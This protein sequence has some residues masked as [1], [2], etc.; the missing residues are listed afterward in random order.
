MQYGSALAIQS[1][2]LLMAYMNHNW[3]LAFCGFVF[4]ICVLLFPPLARL[5]DCIWIWV[6]KTLARIVNPITLTILFIF[7]I[8]PFGMLARWMKWLNPVFT[9]RSDSQL[10]TVESC[11][12]QKSFS[13]PF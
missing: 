8:C 13:K 1:F 11:P 9:R 4:G 7:I 2:I 5:F 6:G 12:S 10:I 3:R